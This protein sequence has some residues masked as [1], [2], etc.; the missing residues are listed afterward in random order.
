MATLI[1]TRGKRFPTPDDGV[2]VQGG[3]WGQISLSRLCD[4]LEHSGEVQPGE[5]ITH[6]V[7]EDGLIR[8][9][10]EKRA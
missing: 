10:V 7:L 8:Y 5:K 2:A 6:L 1:Y 9:R 4:T 3:T